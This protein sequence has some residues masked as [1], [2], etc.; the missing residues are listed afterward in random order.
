[1]S[2]ILVPTPPVALPPEYADILAALKERVRSA[3]YA[4]LKAVNTELVG[5][6][7]DV[8]RLLVERQTDGTNGARAWCNSWLSICSRLLRVLAVFP[9]PTCGG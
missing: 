8:G 4:A 7:W 3:Q 6:Y 2:N 1:M 5:L 9:H